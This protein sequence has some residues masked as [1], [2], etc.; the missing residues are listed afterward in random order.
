MLSLWVQT[1]RQVSITT[2]LLGTVSDTYFAILTTVG[3]VGGTSRPGKLPLL[4]IEWQ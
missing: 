4:L 2:E 1:D 3:K